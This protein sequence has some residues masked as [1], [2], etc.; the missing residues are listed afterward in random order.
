MLSIIEKEVYPQNP[1][2]MLQH[3]Q[4]TY[5]QYVV[6]TNLSYYYSYLSLS[7]IDMFS[8]IQIVNCLINFCV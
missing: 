3:A 2:S 1:T 4:I 5:M 8:C 7:V 6:F